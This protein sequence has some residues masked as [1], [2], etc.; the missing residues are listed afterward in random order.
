[1]ND[2][3]VTQTA[4]AD[5]L[6]AIAER[7][8]IALW[9]LQELESGAAHYLALKTKA[10]R[11]MGQAAGDE[12]IAKALGCPFGVTPRDI[13]GASLFEPSLQTRFDALLA[14][15]NWLVH[16]SLASSRSAVQAD[17]PASALIA[18]IN[19][20][21]EESLA[22]LRVVGAMVEAFVVGSGVS[23]EYIDKQAAVILRGWH[24]PNAA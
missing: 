21:A 24:D 6:A 3:L 12:L 1:M 22:L 15:R 18:R 8:G 9:Q 7:I 2:Y 14:E 10:T 16:K 11:G 4:K 17:A 23:P 20:I 13:A 19:A 5:R